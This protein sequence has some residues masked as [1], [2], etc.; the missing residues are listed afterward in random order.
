MRGMY[1]KP[2]GASYVQRALVAALA[3]VGLIAVERLPTEQRQAYYAEKIEA[4]RTA[5]EAMEIIKDKSASVGVRTMLETDPSGSGMIGLTLS[6]IT[7]G[8]GSLVSKQTS[9][10]P[11]FAAVI[12]EWLKDLDIQSGDVVAVGVSGS[13]PA[14]NVA[15][16]SALHQVG[17]IPIV[18]ASAAASQYGANDPRMTWLDM[19]AALRDAD[20]FPYKSVAASRGGVGDDAIGLARRGQR[21]LDKAIERNE[22][23]K[24]SP[25]EEGVPPAPVVQPLPEDDTQTPDIAQTVTFE[26]QR[27]RTKGSDA[28]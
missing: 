25:P 6:P 16:Y 22:V 14:M 9:V 28:R 4:A 24:L 3:V 8:S 23:P 26:R 27:G 1:W 5:Q 17:A 18:I 15:T 7:S 12:L 10:N 13:F 21:M 20:V 19:E 11:N 2:Q